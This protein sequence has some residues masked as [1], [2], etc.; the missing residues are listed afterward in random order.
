MSKTLMNKSDYFFHL[1][2]EQIAQTP[3]V[4]RDSCKMLCVEKKNPLPSLE[5]NRRR[6]GCLHLP[7]F[8]LAPPK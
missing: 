3:A 8:P 4:P 5:K 6:H 7:R 1:P 2:Q